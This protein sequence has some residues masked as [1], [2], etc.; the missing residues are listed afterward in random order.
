VTMSIVSSIILVL[1]DI[2]GVVDPL[3]N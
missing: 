2:I 3:A 1:M